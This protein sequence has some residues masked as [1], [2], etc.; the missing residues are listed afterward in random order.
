MISF[1]L[2]EKKAW[3][4]ASGIPETESE[5]AYNR[6]KHRLDWLKEKIVHA[7]QSDI[8]EIKNSFHISSNMTKA[9]YLDLVQRCKA[10][11]LDGDIF[12]VNISQEFT[13]K[14]QET[15]IIY[16][17]VLEMCFLVISLS[18]TAIS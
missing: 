5:R 11:I 10:H 7:E 9:S 4:V 1:D 12:Q 17:I 18:F 15:I 8:T 6:A 3:I 13:A 2:L 16:S 14:A